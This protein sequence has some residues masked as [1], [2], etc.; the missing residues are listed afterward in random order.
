MVRPL[1]LIVLL[2]IINPAWG[3]QIETETQLTLP[4]AVFAVT[5]VPMNLYFDNVVLTQSP[6]DCRFVVTCDV[7][8]ATE[9]RW[10]LTATD[11]DVGSH[12]L[13]VSVYNSDGELIESKSSVLIVTAADVLP[14][15]K[16]IRLLIIGDSLTHASAYPNEIARLLSLPGNPKWTMLGTHKPSPAAPEVAHEGYG[17]WTW[18]RFVTHFEPKP[19]NTHRKRSSPFVFLNESSETRLD[20]PRYFQESCEG[21][22]P[23]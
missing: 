3:Q 23:I 15:Q 12:P 11:E 5:G 9:Q 20:M 1:L 2:C 17:G 16:S 21:Q 7:G 8:R 4:P 14:E 10:T 13:R 6:S 22:T 19:D 18:S